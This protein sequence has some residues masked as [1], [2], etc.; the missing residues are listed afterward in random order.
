MQPRPAWE[1]SS[2]KTKQSSGRRRPEGGK[3][4]KESAKGHISV[5]ERKAKG[6]TGLD[7]GQCQ[8]LLAAAT[9]APVDLHWY[10]GDTFP[11]I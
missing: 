7:G 6:G 5:S 2:K 10:T 1:L 8:P 4:E 3:M 9:P 11:E